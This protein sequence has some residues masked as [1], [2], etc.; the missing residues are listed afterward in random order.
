MDLKITKMVKD[1]A[2]VT[3]NVAVNK[4]LKGDNESTQ[5]NP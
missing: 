5:K 4:E 2:N 1:S 3:E